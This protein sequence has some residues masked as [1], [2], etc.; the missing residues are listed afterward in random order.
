M[1][2]LRHSNLLELCHNRAKTLSEDPEEESTG[3][4]LRRKKTD[5]KLMQLRRNK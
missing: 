3:K 5:H 1:K 2:D 4:A